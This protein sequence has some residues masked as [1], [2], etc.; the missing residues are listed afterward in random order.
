MEIKINL[1]GLFGQQCSM[2]FLESEHVINF[3]IAM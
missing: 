1:F 3:L 2:L